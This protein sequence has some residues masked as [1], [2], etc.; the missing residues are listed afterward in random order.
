MITRSW[1]MK[2]T[3][4]I[5]TEVLKNAWKWLYKNATQSSERK[6][7]DY[8]PTSSKQASTGLQK[9]IHH[10]REEIE[11]IHRYPQRL[12]FGGKLIPSR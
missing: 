2:A 1:C 11:L 4:I 7:E 3:I 8:L 9:Q 6:Y 10:G 12:L 5:C